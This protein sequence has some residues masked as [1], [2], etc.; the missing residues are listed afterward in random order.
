MPFQF[1]F[2]IDGDKQL[3]RTLTRFSD[4]IEHAGTGG[5]FDDMA[6]TF[7]QIEARQFSSSGANSGGWA[8]LS[9]GYA[10]WKAR[11]YPGKGVLVRSG[12]LEASLTGR[13]LGVEVITDDRAL[14]GTGVPYAG[15]H[16]HGTPKMPRRRPLEFTGTQRTEL[17]KS[18]Q[19]A[20]VKLLRAAH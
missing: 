16:Q 17:T 4:V 20:L 10:A 11:H 2:S 19:R 6:D 5:V 14:F 15:Y 8:A 13:P 18:G 12:A 1:E 7:G 9:P 3:S